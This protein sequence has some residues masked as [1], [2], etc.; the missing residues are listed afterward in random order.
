MVRA[1]V[2]YWEGVKGYGT[3]VV[4]GGGQYDAIMTGGF[5]EIIE[6][7]VP[8]ISD[9]SMTLKLKSRFDCYV[10]GED[11][12]DYNGTG[13]GEIYEVEADILSDNRISFELRN[14]AGDAG[15]LFF[16]IRLAGDSEMIVDEAG[17][18]NDGEISAHYYLTYTLNKRP[19]SGGGD[20]VPGGDSGY[21]GFGD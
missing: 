6:A 10:A 13:G 18:L 1:I 19:G 16:E 20:P 12:Y 4:D 15:S 8:I 5:M 3:L 11:R 2:G 7:S 9:G 21:Y 14:E 17:Y